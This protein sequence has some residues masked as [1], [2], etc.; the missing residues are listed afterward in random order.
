M[1]WGNNTTLEEQDNTQEDSDESD[2]VFEPPTP[3]PFPPDEPDSLVNGSDNHVDNKIKIPSPPDP[4][5][6][7]VSREDS[8][9]EEDYIM[10]YLGKITDE[11]S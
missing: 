4:K 9:D 2:G 5:N 6:F 7:P 3:P 1:E 8:G 11:V 10:D